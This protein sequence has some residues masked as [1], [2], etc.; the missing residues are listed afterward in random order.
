MSPR[1]QR[2]PD[3]PDPKS[4]IHAVEL[5]LP[6]LPAGLEGLRIAHVTD[7]HISRPRPRR[8]HRQAIAALMGVNVSAVISFVSAPAPTPF[9]NRARMITR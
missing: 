4:L 1:S 8:R 2:L 9:S 3:M 7:L 6:H 5:A